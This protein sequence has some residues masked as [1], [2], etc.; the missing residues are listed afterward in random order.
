M[1][2]SLF[3]PSSFFTPPTV[4]SV[5][6]FS[7]CVWTL[8]ISLTDLVVFSL[9]VTITDFLETESAS[10]LVMTPFDTNRSSVALSWP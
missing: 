10:C 9:G 8:P 3:V 2:K 5:V 1:R 7:Y 4:S 6:M